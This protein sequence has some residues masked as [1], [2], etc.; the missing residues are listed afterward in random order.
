MKKILII[1]LGLFLA[2]GGAWM[3]FS[4][5]DGM[6]YRN[7]E[8]KACS[9]S[10]GGGMM[11]GYSRSSLKRDGAGGAVLTVSKKETHASREVTTVYRVDPA[12]FDRLREIVNQY[13]LY[14]ASKR[15]YSKVQ[16]MDGETTSLS[17]DYEKGYFSISENQVLSSGMKEGFRETE[18]FLYS[19]AQGEGERSVE[20]QTAM[21]YLRSGYT[22][23]FSVQ[24]AFDGKLEGIL[25]EDHETE[26]TD[27]GIL[28]AVVNDLDCTD[29]QPAETGA[30]GTIVYE[31]ESGRI[32]ILYEDHDFGSPVY[33]LAGL[34][35]HTSSAFP[36][37]AQMEGEY[38]MY[39]N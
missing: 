4:I 31:P 18:R 28:F 5:V 3:M 2:A 26:K 22:L 36:L 35:G 7:D 6:K 12:V 37:I 20:P 19:L 8:M 24:D 9:V 14:R 15:P 30:A 13:D 33:V 25:D 17:F 16:V 32:I 11:G 34:E 21:L 10:S 29:A 23:Q 1:L 38:R 27:A 39:L